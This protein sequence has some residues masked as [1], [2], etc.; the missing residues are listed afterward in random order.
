MVS[1]WIKTRTGIIYGIQSVF[2]TLEKKTKKKTYRTTSDFISP[3]K[4]DTNSPSVLGYDAQWGHWPSERHI[5]AVTCLYVMTNRIMIHRCG[6]LIDQGRTMSHAPLI[7]PASVAIPD[8]HQ[9]VPQW[10]AEKIC[11]INAA[12]Q[13]LTRELDKLHHPDASDDMAEFF[14]VEKNTRPGWIH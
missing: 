13:K 5:M 12:P 4:W 2:Q 8:L 10:G 1:R 9:R 11:P 7:W 6:P 14:T 3:S